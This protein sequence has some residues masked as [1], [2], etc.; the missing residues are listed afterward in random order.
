MLEVAIE[1]AT[2][3]VVDEPIE[4]AIEAVVAEIAIEVAVPPAIKGGATATGFAGSATPRTSLRPPIRAVCAAAS[5]GS[6][7]ESECERTAD[8]DD[9]DDDDEAEGGWWCGGVVVVADT[10]KSDRW[11]AEVARGREE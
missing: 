3:A 10:V 1:A 4:E 2:E 7:G 8:D 9:D 5:K 6:E 11:R